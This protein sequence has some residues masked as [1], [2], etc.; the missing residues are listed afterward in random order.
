MRSTMRPNWFGCLALAAG[1]GLA[2][3]LAAQ[4]NDKDGM[5]KDSMKHEP[6]AKDD[7]MAHDTMGHE[8]MGPHGSFAGAGQHH[9][10]GSFEIV[11]AQGNRQIKLGDDFTLDKVPDPYLVLA[12]AE[13]P[14]AKSVYIAKLKSIKGSQ[15][16]EIPAGAD[17]SGFTR[18]LLWCKKYSVLIGSAD[19]A[20]DDM[21]HHDMMQH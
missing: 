6:M 2:S 8:A 16:Y 3:P 18:V 1:L 7:K 20:R 14:D 15:A 19:L 11:M 17:L 5:K 4:A 12:S 13:Q 21:M 9:A 10:G